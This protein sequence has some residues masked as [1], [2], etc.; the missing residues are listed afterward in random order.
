MDDN[1]KL[2][3][4]SGQAAAVGRPACRLHDEKYFNEDIVNLG[5]A[6]HVTI[7]E[8][9]R[10]VCEVV[11]DEGSPTYKPA[12][13]TT[14]A[15]DGRYQIRRQPRLESTDTAGSEVASDLPVV[16]RQHR[17]CSGI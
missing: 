17:K 10:H 15:Q 1:E 14:R 7:L 16:P 13:P 2:P 12:V 5:P 11:G 9:V 3:H 4:L 6:Y 8:F